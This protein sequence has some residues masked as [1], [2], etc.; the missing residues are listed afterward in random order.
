MDVFQLRKKDESFIGEVVCC[1][2]LRDGS[3]AEKMGARLDDGDFL[4]QIKQFAD[5]PALKRHDAREQ[6]GD[7]GGWHFHLSHF[8]RSPRRQAP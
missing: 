8:L 5:S 1:L 4:F 2:I 7:D 3:G 6:N